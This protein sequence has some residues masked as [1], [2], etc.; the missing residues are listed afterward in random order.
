M[1][2][3][4][5]ASRTRQIFCPHCKSVVPKS[6]YYRHRSMYYDVVSQC[7]TVANDD[8]LNE[9]EWQLHVEE[10]STSLGFKAS[11]EETW[12]I[13]DYMNDES[14]AVTTISDDSSRTEFSDDVGFT[15]PC[16]LGQTQPYG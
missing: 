16:L 11:L 2:K 1:S 8:G 3:M 6:S 15:E 4:E 13:E 5:A 7:W 14:L 12:N 9:A 10:D